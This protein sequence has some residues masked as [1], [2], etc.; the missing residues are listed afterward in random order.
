M[1]RDV[2]EAAL[3]RCWGTEFVPAPLASMEGCL[4]GVENEGLRE[5]CAAEV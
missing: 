3:W 1:D 5:R 4:A 2:W